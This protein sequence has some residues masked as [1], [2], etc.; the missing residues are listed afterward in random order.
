MEMQP[1]QST[2]FSG[3][4]SDQPAQLWPLLQKTSRTFALSIPLLPEPLQTEVAIAY[5]LFRIIDTF[6]DA[7]RWSPPRRAEA[8]E[9]FVHFLKEESGEQ[10]HGKLAARW[11]DDPPL[12]HKGY[13]DLLAAAPE[14][15]QWHH[16]L[17]PAAGE[18]L[19]RNVARSARGMAEVVRRIDS[20]GR[21]QLETLQDLRDYCFVVAGIVGEMLTELFL[22]QT[23]SLQAVAGDLR[24]RAVEFGEGLQLVNILKDAYADGAE[25]RS[26]LPRAAQVAEVFMLARADLRRAVEYTELA[27][28]AGAARGV[29]AFNALNV[30]LAIATLHLLRDRGPGAKMS[31]MQVATVAA[32]VM[33][34]VDTG[35]VLFPERP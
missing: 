27:R 34:A 13:L 16:Q 8:L 4:A 15:I 20:T 14:V 35:G 6:E 5:L 29:I 10:D 19:R 17:R 21:L 11:L 3:K 18:Q 24:A 2:T 26:Y 25:R 12:D 7:T 28:K 22:L 32:Q 33:N 1:E 31:R 30:R 23:P 9:Q